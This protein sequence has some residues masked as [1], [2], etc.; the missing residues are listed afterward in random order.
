MVLLKQQWRGDRGNLIGWAIA[1][2]ALTWF[3]VSMYDS[4]MSTGM[5]N[6]LAE[7]L[8]S[9]PAAMQAW[10]AGGSSLVTFPGFVAGVV[11]N[12]LMLV[13]AAIYVA[14]YIPNIITREMDQRN[15]EF[16][17]SL[18]V[19]RS[20]VIVTRWLGFIVGLAGLL[21]IQWLA[22]V[23]SAGARGNAL[24]YLIADLNMFLLF[25]AVGGLIMFIS[26]FIDDQSRCTGIGMAL[27]LGL[28]FVYL[29]TDQA[30]G[31]VAALRKALPF[32]HFNPG[33]IISFGAIPW[34]D[35]VGLA[36]AAAVLLFLSVK[37]FE[38][39][40]IAA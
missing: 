18:P 34:G 8:R 3:M 13:M 20:T 10:L 40:Q 30:T 23:A 17:L 2:T 12:G 5:M 33:E 6:D 29:M 24:R 1:L 16:L 28:L 25:A 22:L 15:M 4:L 31:A 39:K 37:A 38:R 35:M 21:A 36:I 9:M 11:F 7:V 26:V 19:R 27:S 32:A 14:L